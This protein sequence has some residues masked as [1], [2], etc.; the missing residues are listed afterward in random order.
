ML[1]LTTTTAT[2]AASTAA[3]AAADP[4][5][6][7]YSYSY[8]FCYFYYYYF[9]YYYYY[10]DYDSYCRVYSRV[11]L[12]YTVQFVA[13]GMNK[14]SGICDRL[15]AETMVIIVGCSVY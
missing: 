15:S 1:L 11:Y 3:A 9:Y 7:S 10:D 2:A 12:L 4:Y 13:T 8:C 14:G 5:S 6:N